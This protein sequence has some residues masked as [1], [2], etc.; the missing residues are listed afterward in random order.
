VTQFN[1]TTFSV[2]HVPEEGSAADLVIKFNVGTIFFTEGFWDY[3]QTHAPIR[4]RYTYNGPFESGRI[5][6][7]EIPAFVEATRTWSRR[8]EGDGLVQGVYSGTPDQPRGEAEVTYSEL[9]QALNT[10]EDA[11]EQAFVGR[12]FLHVVT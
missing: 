7:D 5:E 3:C 12:T 1:P 10:I 4:D 2:G 8:Y 9:R 11:A 6:H